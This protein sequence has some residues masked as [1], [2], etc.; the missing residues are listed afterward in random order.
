MKI[1]KDTLRKFDLTYVKNANPDPK[2]KVGQEHATVAAMNI[3][4]RSFPKYLVA[5]SFYSGV[6]RAKD[7]LRA[8]KGLSDLDGEVGKMLLG[9]DLY[10]YSIGDAKAG[11]YIMAKVSSN[12]A[13]ACFLGYG[14]KGVED[15]DIALNSSFQHFDDLL[16]ILLFKKYADIET[17]FVPAG[18]TKDLNEARY[19]NQSKE[20]IT[21]LDCRW[22]TNI[23]RTEGFAVSG[24]FRL[25]PH[26]EQRS[27]RKLVWINEFQKDGYTH[28]AKLM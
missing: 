7:R 4:G 9:E 27:K 28:T 21:V 16:N 2:A 18:E 13:V 10:V 12:V 20:D 8:S 1:T 11:D 26:G 22:F 19:K 6:L 3:M 14:T 25:Q 24:H 17:V 5:D 15:E 23:V